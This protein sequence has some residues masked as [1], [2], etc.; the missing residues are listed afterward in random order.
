MAE[1]K[2]T[3]EDLRKAAAA[4]SKAKDRL[5][6][7]FDDGQFTEL[8][9]FAANNAALSGVV[10][11]FGKVGSNPCY[12]FSQDVSVNGGALNRIQAQKI[13]AL[14]D[15]AAKTGVPIVGIYDSNG[16]DLNDGHEA[17]TA[18]GELLLKLSNLSGVVPQ[19]AVVAGVC[20]GTSALLAE[21]A[22]FTII[23]EDAQLYVSPNANIKSSSENALKNGTAA[24]A[25]ENDKDAVEKARKLLGSLP[26]NNLSPLPL[27]EYELPVAVSCADAQSTAESIFDKDSITE[28]YA[29]F[30]S[31]SYTALAS[32][33]GKVTGVVA[34]NKTADKLNADDCTK[35]ARF[36]RVCDS[37]SIPVVTFVDTKGFEGNSDTEAAGAVKNMA[38][39]AHAYA[40]A[41]TAKISVVSGKAYGAAFIT[42][43]G[44]GANSDF[45]FALDT[46]VIT[47]LDPST[48]AEFFS[49]DELKGASDIKAKR[50]ELEDRYAA[51]E[52]NPY[53]AAA[54][55]C[56]DG[57]FSADGLRAALAAAL[58][59][60]SGKRVSRLPKK[61]SNIQL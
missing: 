12:A 46:A 58:E 22:D 25:A 54:K 59:Q 38:K 53:I 26:L 2:L 21:S 15:L 42:L 57:V 51:T 39:L 31:A 3:A 16:A 61:H 19:I 52:G 37:F 48:A 41:T 33:E 17:L 35:I 23:S 10:T 44:R 56:V 24:L 1:I 40:E 43:A 9:A 55:G 6:Y 29:G 60:L 27:C 34:T 11:A 13:A 36:V 32:L 18:Y 20:S 8:D 45:T 49:H 7:L 5:T 4:P 50:K 30:G 14:I 47:A 28:L